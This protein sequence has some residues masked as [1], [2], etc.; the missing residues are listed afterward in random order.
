MI[1]A[2]P[3]W[4]KGQPPQSTTGVART[5]CSQVKAPGERARHRLPG[6]SSLTWQQKEGSGQGDAHP[7]PAGHIHQA[8][9]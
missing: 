4:K 9:G 2:Q 5:N 6:R 1:E 8:L 7:E 3:R